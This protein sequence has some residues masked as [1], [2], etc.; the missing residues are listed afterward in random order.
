MYIFY[1]PTENAL[2]MLNDQIYWVGDYL[3]SSDFFQ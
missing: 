1:Y 2:L 3:N